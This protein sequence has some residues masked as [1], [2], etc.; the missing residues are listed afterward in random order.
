VTGIVSTKLPVV[1]GGKKVAGRS[2]TITGRVT[3]PTPMV[4]KPTAKAGGSSQ[5]KRAE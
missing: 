5:K 4:K 1:R 2:K 3:K